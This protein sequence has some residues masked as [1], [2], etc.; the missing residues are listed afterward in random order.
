MTWTALASAGSCQRRT[1]VTQ[2]LGVFG[3]Q[4]V[5][6]EAGVPRRRGGDGDRSDGEIAVDAL[7]D[8]RGE[9]RVFVEFRVEGEVYVV[10]F[11]VFAT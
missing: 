4:R 10:A 3:R 11:T 5:H 8:Q 1:A 2:V 9:H 6:V 7:F